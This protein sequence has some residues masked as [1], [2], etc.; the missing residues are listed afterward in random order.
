MS[1]LEEVKELNENI[2]DATEKYKGSI[3]LAEEIKKDLKVFL[4]SVVGDIIPY[5]MEP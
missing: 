3:K 5:L 4:I 1:R 2:R